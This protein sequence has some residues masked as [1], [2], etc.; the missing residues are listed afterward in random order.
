[1]FWQQLTMTGYCSS[2]LWCDKNF[3]VLNSMAL[4]VTERF[5]IAD[6]QSIDWSQYDCVAI[7]IESKKAADEVKLNLVAKGVPETKIIWERPAR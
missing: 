6:P 4:N 2:V 1:M 3:A 5:E 7:A